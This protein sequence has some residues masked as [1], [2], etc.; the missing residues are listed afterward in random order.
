MLTILFFQC[1]L[2][3][4]V[5]SKIFQQ[6]DLKSLILRAGCHRITLFCSC[7]SFNV[8]CNPKS[9]PIPSPPTEA[10]RPQLPL[11][12]MFMGFE[13][14]TRHSMYS[15]DL[16]KISIHSESFDLYLHIFFSETFSIYFVYNP[17]LYYFVIIMFLIS[18]LPSLLYNA[19]NCSRNA[20]VVSF[21]TKSTASNNR[22]NF[23]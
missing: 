4:R 5:G 21:A 14:T 12:R 19:Y 13:V 20:S 17:N 23:Y 2:F 8:N 3:R 1:V 22:F 16:W 15:T 7:I 18:L 6:F 11:M 10:T 9:V